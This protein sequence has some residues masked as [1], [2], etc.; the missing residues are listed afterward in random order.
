MPASAGMVLFF[1]FLVGEQLIPCSSMAQWK[2]LADFGAQVIYFIN[3]PGPPRIGFAISGDYDGLHKTT[4]GGQTWHQISL[5]I[6][7][8]TNTFFNDITFKDSLTGWMA[9][10]GSPPSIGGDGGCVKTTDGGETWSP[11]LSGTENSDALQIYYN[12]K[13]GGLFL[14]TYGALNHNIV[15]WDEGATWETQTFSGDLGYGGCAFVNDDSGVMASDDI[16]LPRWYRT[17]NAGLTWSNLT[18]DSALVQPLAILG[19]QTYFANT[20]NGAILRTDDAWDTWHDVYRFPLLPQDPH[21]YAVGAWSQSMGYICGDSNNLVVQAGPGCWRSTNQGTTWSYLCG[22][23]FGLIFDIWKCFMKGHDLY[24]SSDSGA[25]ESI[26]YLNLD[27]LN[28]FSSSMSHASVSGTGNERSV[29]FQPNIEASAAVDTVH[30]SLRYDS[31]LLLDSISIPANWHILDSSSSGNVLTVTIFDTSTTVDTP[32][33]TLNFRHFVTPS[34]SDGMVWLDSARLFGKWMNCD[35]YAQSATASDSVQLSFPNC[36]DTLLLDAME[37]KPLFTIQS[38]VPNPAQSEITVRVVSAD[39]GGQVAA[40]GD[41]HAIG[42]EL[43]DA[44]GES[45]ISGIYNTD[46]RSTSLRIDVS[47]LPAGTYYLRLSENGYVETRK[48]AIAR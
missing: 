38:I 21:P 41:H 20:F 19:T 33:I 7:I 34:S 42:Y 10:S 26:W 22:P 3:L 27:S 47:S 17:T 43:F 32:S 23:G 2:K 30:F 12:K 28:I 5:P 25:S 16:W 44:L 36:A 6:D 15:S 24:V 35:I 11:I 9:V 1:L 13:S 40:V 4:D 31:S 48:V 29:T 46:V 39:P 45:S 37:G 14:S 18:M 8:D